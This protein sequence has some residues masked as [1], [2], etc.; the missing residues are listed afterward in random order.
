M[1]AMDPP[2]QSVF[3]HR[4]RSAWLYEGGLFQ[5]AQTLRREYLIDSGLIQMGTGDL[6]ID[7]GANIGDF[8]LAIDSLGIPDIS[9]FGFE[10][11]P[12]DF[13]CLSENVGRN[14]SHDIALY[15]SNGVVEFY[16]DSENA[17]SSVIN[18]GSYNEVISL[19]SARLDTLY[20]K[21]RIKLFKVEAEGAEL[22]V[23]EGATGLLPYIEFISIDAGFERGPN[24]ETTMPNCTN[25][26]LRNGFE[27]IAVGSGR[28]TALFRNTS[29]GVGA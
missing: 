13:V 22:E 3:N 26:L 4:Y 15:N 7:C 28:L 20:P 17:D 21:T 10:P 5:R 29:T 2:F 23:L 24:K 11:S 6:V 27:L 8:K 25:F 18:P 9:Y 19:K 1:L 14:S 16:M 12:I